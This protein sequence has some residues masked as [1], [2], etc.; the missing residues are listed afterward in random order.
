MAKNTVIGA[1][2][3]ASNILLYTKGFL[4]EVNVDMVKIE[5]KLKS[6]IKTNISNT[7]HSL[8]DLAKMGHPYSRARP[9]KVHTPDYIV[10]RQTGEMLKG[11]KS[12]TKAAGLSSG[13]LKA[14]AFAG[15]ADNVEHAKYV[16]FGTSKMVPRDFLRGSLNEIRKKVFQI[17]KR[18]LNKTTI[19]F[20]GKK[21]KL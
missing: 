17:L 7:E 11:L 5:K 4:R 18:S 6:T 12:G 2:T 1:E 19:S 3:I 14:E 10:H 20:K 8:K 15:I 21:V 9:G 16:I 13:K